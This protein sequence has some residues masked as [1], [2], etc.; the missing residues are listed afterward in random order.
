MIE[1]G[2]NR[3]VSYREIE[4]EIGFVSEIEVIQIVVIESRGPR[5]CNFYVIE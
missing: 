3:R 4:R 1:I 2:W 5:L